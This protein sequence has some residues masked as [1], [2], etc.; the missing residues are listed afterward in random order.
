MQEVGRWLLLAGVALAVLGGVIWLLGRMGFRGLPGDVS[1]ESQNVR[2]Y[3]PIVTCIF[4]SILLTL[5]LWIW[6]WIQRK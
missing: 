2:V 5:G 6:R 3:F 4:L 1:Y